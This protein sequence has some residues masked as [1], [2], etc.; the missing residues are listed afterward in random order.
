MTAVNVPEL[1]KNVPFWEKGLPF[2]LEA[3]AWLLGE[4]AKMAAA[5]KSAREEVLV[6]IESMNTSDSIFHVNPI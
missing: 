3:P 2:L 4:P 5:R 1:L 6:V